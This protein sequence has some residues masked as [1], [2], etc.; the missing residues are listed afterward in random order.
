MGRP[1][2]NALQAAYSTY[3]LSFK[4]STLTGIVEVSSDVCVAREC[5]FATLQAA[6]SSTAEPKIEDR[7]SNILSIDCIDPQQSG[8][9]K[10]LETKDEVE[11][12]PLNPLNPDQ[13][14]RVGTSLSEPLK[15]ELTFSKNTRTSS[16][17][18]PNKLWGYPINLC[19]M[20]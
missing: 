18:L 14:I 8:K 3:H 20:N 17:G 5:Y 4:F 19:C 15:G 9:P 12:I 13:T 16:P 6:F 2:L 11:K 7:R 10:K 1:T